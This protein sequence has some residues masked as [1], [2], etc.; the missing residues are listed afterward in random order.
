LWGFI[1]DS[2]DL[3]RVNDQAC[4]ELWVG[5]RR[6]FKKLGSADIYALTARLD[7]HDPHPSQK[8]EDAKNHNSKMNERKLIY[9][10]IQDRR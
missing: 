8:D 10:A 5:D 4:I 2:I 7:T 3:G 1:G 9:K 6:V